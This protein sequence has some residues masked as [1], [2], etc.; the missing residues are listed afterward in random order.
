MGHAADRSR[1]HDLIVLELLA[2]SNDV[3]LRKL[4]AAPW[5]W[6]QRLTYPLFAL[7]VTHAFFYGAFLRMASPFTL[8]LVVGIV[9]VLIGQAAGF[10]LWRRKRLDGARTDTVS[11]AQC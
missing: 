3:T 1:D 4:K 11:T 9:A 2:T 8:L 5:K 6:L 7:V 10:R